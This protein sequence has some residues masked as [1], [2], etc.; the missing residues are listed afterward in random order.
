MNNK[1]AFTLIELLVV[2]AIIALLM[3]ILMP[4][5]AK[6]KKQALKV[7]DLAAKHQMAI[8]TAS[9]T[10]DADGYFWGRPGVGSVQA[11]QK[12]WMYTLKPYYKDPQMRFCPAAKNPKR[13]TGPF[14]TWNY[15]GLGSY[16]PTADPSLLMK[17][18]SEYDVRVGRV[19]QGFFTGSIG[20]NRFIENMTAGPD[21]TSTEFW[22]KSDIKGADKVPV[23]IDSQYCYFSVYTPDV[24]PPDYD[25]AF[26]QSEMEWI[27][28]NRH[29]GYVGAVFADWSARMVGLKELW[30]L[31][32]FR[33]YDTCGSWTL[34][35][36]NGKPA[37]GWP[38]W[39]R[40]FKDY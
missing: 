6:A 19:I 32:F 8:S 25:G 12:L 15:A 27:C 18:E 24:D 13:V 16:S 30:T 33:S 3:S 2:I 21:A 20:L 23:F 17:D 36:N 22:R 38:P 39:M 5:L 26:G 10:S 31:K 4:A 34:C 1:R 11:Y 35:G 28:I 40:G 29:M 14:G 9:Y 37:T 7:A